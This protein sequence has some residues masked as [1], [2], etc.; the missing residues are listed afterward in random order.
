MKHY[1]VRMEIDVWMDSP[2][3]AALDTAYWLYEEGGANRAV[4]E[5]I[6][7][8]SGKTVKIDLEDRTIE[9]A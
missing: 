9:D 3:E 2:M 5:I 8:E 4:Y 6:D 1:L 7:V